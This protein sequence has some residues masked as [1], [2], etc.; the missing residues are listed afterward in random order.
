MNNFY[1]VSFV[2]HNVCNVQ[3]NI[4]CDSLEIFLLSYFKLLNFENSASDSYFADILF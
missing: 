2:Q 4:A 1:M 3:A